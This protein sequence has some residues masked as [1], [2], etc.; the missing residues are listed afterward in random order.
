MTVHPSISAVALT[1]WVLAGSPASA[2]EPS[3]QLIVD[4]G[5]PLR[6]ALDQKIKVQRIGQGT[7][8]A[9]PR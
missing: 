4:A 5:R 8:Q 6:V 7:G 9:R 3:I 2:E 1:V